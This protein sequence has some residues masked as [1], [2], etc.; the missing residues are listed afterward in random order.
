MEDSRV[1]L[2]Q[3]SHSPLEHSD[4]IR[5]I[6]LQPLS[7]FDSGLHCDILHVRLQENLLYE[8]LSYAWGPQIFPETIKVG[9]ENYLMITSNLASALKHLRSKDQIRILW[10]DAISIN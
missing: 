9:R 10:I 8:A 5:L 6:V 1:H 3:F 7:S 4:C 2:K